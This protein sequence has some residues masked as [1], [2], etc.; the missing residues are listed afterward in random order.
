MIA[1]VARM[2]HERGL[3]QPQIAADLHISQPRVSRLL[4][5]ASELGIVRTIVTLPEGVHSEV[6]DALIDAYAKYGLTNAIVTESSDGVELKRAL[7]A[8]AAQYLSATLTGD[9]RVGIS[10]W[11]AT[12]LAVAEAMRP[13]RSRTAAT[14]VQVMGGLGDPRVQMQASRLMALF[15]GSTRAEP[16]FMPAPGVLVSREARD[17]LVADPSVSGV[18]DR[19]NELTV[20][21]EGI[22]PAM[23]SQLLRESG[24][25]LADSD[26][27]SL[28]AAG[29]VG[30]V[31]LRFFDADG[32]PIAS[33]VND[34]VISISYDTL[35]GIPRRVGIAGGPEKHA[36]IRAALVGGW[37]N[38]LIT[39]LDEAHRLLD[40]AT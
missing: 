22:G 21:L 8:A 12:L 2:Y 40:S 27:A 10:S 34:R 20:V 23:G 25:A 14:V 33:S 24:N 28:M 38:I 18:M 15:A 17:S 26:R 36:A 11:S 4:K 6:E 1:S 16:V 31:C 7:G 39:D 3:T 29:A 35:R 19:W 30:D 37:A 9:D 5:R 32:Q 13:A